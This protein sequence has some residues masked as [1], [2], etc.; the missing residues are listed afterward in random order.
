MKVLGIALLGLVFLIGAYMG[1]IYLNLWADHRGTGLAVETQVPDD[2]TRERQASQQRAMQAAAVGSDKQILFGDFHVHSTFSFDAFLWSLPIM[3]GDGA[4]PIAD[5]CDYARFCSGIDFWSI[6]DHAESSTTRRWRETR[7]AIRQC[8]AIE[9]DENP[10][11]ISFHGFEW[12]QVGL[13]PELHY[14]HKNVIFKEL[15]DDQ[16]A[17]R[18]ITSGGV[19]IAVLRQGALPPVTMPLTDFGNRQVYFDFRNYLAETQRE[20]PCDG[21]DE[22]A[23]CYEIAETPDALFAKLD[24]VK[25]ENMVIPHGTTW[26]FY[27]PPSST[28]DKQLTARMRPERQE[29]LEIMSGHGNSEEFRAFNAQLTDEQGNAICPEK[30]PEYTPTCHRAGEIIEQRCLAE[31]GAAEVCAERAAQ[32]RQG[33]ANMGIA[34]HIGLRGERPE[35]YLDAGQCKDCF[36]P[37]FNYRPGGSAQYGLAITNFDDPHN[38]RR[39]RFGFIASSDNHR[40]RP[41]T[42]YKAVQRTRT[43]EASGPISEEWNQRLTNNAGDEK[44]ESTFTE[45]DPLTLPR[46]FAL[47]ERERQ[48]SFWTTGGLVAVHSNSRSREGIWKALE[49]REVY[50][51][52]GPR[53]LL[54]FDKLEKDGSIRPMGSQ[55]TSGTTPR[56][57][58]SALGA[59]KQKP[60][61]PDFSRAALGE[62]RLQSLCAGECFN[63]GDE[64][65]RITA[66]DIIRIRPQAYKGE[67]VKQLIEDPWK[68][69]E[70]PADGSGC[71]IE[72]SDDTFASDGR[73]SLYYARAI[74]EPTPTINGD[75]LRCEYDAEGNC[76][77][78]N[79]CQG[80]SY[81]TPADDNC[82][83]MK[84]HRAWSSPI[85]V[86]FSHGKRAASKLKSSL[87]VPQ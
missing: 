28:L 3:G 38:P 67:D 40:A 87:T 32:A 16:I 42:G 21:S 17:K 20:M 11:L 70:C 8:N 86:D 59:H 12:T 83:A 15:A 78:V 76:I 72:F 55:V 22:D 63:P 77:K 64:R 9:D 41:G 84:A 37:S 58:V 85:F 65:L 48:S 27:T 68:R 18:P 14:G 7:E 51:T 62:E 81:L 36:L 33:Y 1:G 80:S 73:D 44:P 47:T 4:H 50:G 26:G 54:W 57:R 30:T 82:T 23:P 43:T 45:A 53:M 5:A 56:F 35:D 60:G 24:A 74:Q 71:T 66:I 79:M 75:N 6:N 61:C 10:G 25:G 69:F 19:A 31:D 29:L 46:S 2:F 13:L 39:F 49:T 34:G 52:S